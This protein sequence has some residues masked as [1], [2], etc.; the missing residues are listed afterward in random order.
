MIR[1]V[2]CVLV[3]CIM[4]A[5]GCAPA[6]SPPAEM[7]PDASPDEPRACLA[8]T[9]SGQLEGTRSEGTCS[10]K[11]IP[12]AAPPVGPLRFRPPEPPVAWTDVR[13]ADDFGEP[14]VQ[15]AHGG[16]TGSED[17][18]T[19]NV[20]TPV[21]RTE[22]LPILFYIHGGSNVSGSSAEYSEGAYWYVAVDALVDLY[23]SSKYGTP[24]DAYIALLTDDWYTCTVRRDLR[25]VTTGQTQP[26]WRAYFAHTFEQ[27]PARAYGAG[28]G[29]DLYFGF[30]SFGTQPTTAAELALAD[31]MVGY[32]T[33]FAATGDPNGA[34]AFAWP[35]YDRAQDDALV[36]DDHLSVV[37][38]IDADECD[39]WDWY[40]GR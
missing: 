28:H 34:D 19:L 3:G 30:H 5:A 24:R 12:Y 29:V 2:P 17:C 14:C 23:P 18:L 20:W 32:W 8:V 27:G 39:Y 31:A 4:P 13:V 35:S 6:D 22:P 9:A 21:E 40:R 11:G 25:A 7:D 16:P 36:L 26:V 10:Y 37:G 1:L 38:P 15:R 33:R